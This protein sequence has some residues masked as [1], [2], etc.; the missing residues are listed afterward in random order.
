MLFDFD[1]FRKRVPRYAPSARILH[2][3]VKAMFETFGDQKDLETGL[4]LFNQRAWD[5]ANNILTEIGDGHGSDSPGVS[6][7]TYKLDPKTRKPMVDSDGLYL[8]KSLRGTNAVEQFHRKLRDFLGS[9]HCGVELAVCLLSE[10]IHRHKHAQAVLHDLDYVNEHHVDFW[11]TDRY[12]ILYHAL[13]GKEV[14]PE[15]KNALRDFASTGEGMIIMP[16]TSTKLDVRQ[17]CLDNAP[18]NMTAD[19]KFM[20]RMM[21]ETVPPLPL[22]TKEEMVQYKIHLKT[23]KSDGKGAHWPLINRGLSCS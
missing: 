14:M 13:Y 8:Y 17:E 2:A 12:Q 22:V 11:L 5:T 6:F 23:F 18:S 10:F 19:V 7:Y 21:G 16:L 20:A 1:Y 15:R 4:P 3:R 9:W